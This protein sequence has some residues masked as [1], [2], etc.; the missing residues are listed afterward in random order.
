M[1]FWKSLFGDEEAAALKRAAVI[2]VP[3]QRP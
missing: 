2:V 1:A 3:V